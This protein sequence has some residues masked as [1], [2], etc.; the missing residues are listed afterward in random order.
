MQR[1]ATLLVLGLLLA[2]P[3]LAQPD[4]VG[5]D[6]MWARDIGSETIAVDGTLDEGVWSQAES[7]RILWNGD[8]P[9]PGGGQTI[10][11]NPAG[12]DDPIDPTDATVY[13]LRKGNELYLGLQ[14]DDASVGGDRGFFA[15]DGLLMTLV[16]K[17]DRPETFTDINNY[18]EST[19]V[20]E[21]MFYGWQHPA[22]TTDTGAQVPGIGPRAWSTDFGLTAGDSADATPRNPEVWEYAAT[23]DGVSND[24]FN[25]G[26][27]FT[28]DGGYTMEMRIRLDSLGWDLTQAMA[29]MPISIAVE[30]RDFAWPLDADRFTRTRAWWQGRWLNNFNEG[31]AYIAGDPS[32][33]VTSGPVPAYTEP[34]F[35]VPRVDSNVPIVVDGALDEAA[36]GLVDPQFQLQYQADGDALDAGLPGVLAPNYTFY[37]HPDANPVLDP[38]V[39]RFTMFYKDSYL[40]VGLDTDDQAVNGSESE[41][42]RDGFRL[43]IRSRDSTQAGLAFTAAQLRM[44]L[45]IDSTGSVRFQSVSPEIFEPGAIVA[46]V[47]MKSGSTVADPTDIDAGYQME[48]A[49]D[50]R[51]IGYDD[52]V[53]NGGQIYIALN[54]FD[55]D[56]LEDDAQS[57]GTRTWIIG[58][59]SNGAS[60]YGYL[61]PNVVVQTAAANGPDAPVLRALG[62]AP[63]PTTGATALRYVLPQASRVT[64][65]VFDV[66]GRRV[67]T[68]DAGLQAA[69]VGSVSLDASALGAGTYVYR[70]RTADGA[71]VTSQLVVVR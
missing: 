34:E 32:V 25:G 41:N 39:G 36:W 3:A 35:T 56:A 26:S 27:A 50:L 33:T 20:R 59:R 31:A 28:A 57:Y 21:E 1:T 43:Q 51:A 2:G 7:Y 12:L 54:Y 47:A 6:V 65:E 55:G 15:G 48:M 45:S 69:G 24:D 30:D 66:L 53:A 71:S 58:E 70:V 11:D 5:Q 46:G 22:D 29:R 63:N 13:F 62:A 49:L 67:T 42:T 10:E 18:F 68:V 61:D 14:V 60:L 17:S 37:F 19:A 9:F 64:V 40:Y 52:L 16:R 38:T 4:R 44:D 23:V 8:H